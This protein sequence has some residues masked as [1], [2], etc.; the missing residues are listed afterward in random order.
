MK[1]L[2][3]GSDT[4]FAT[5]ILGGK[6]FPTKWT[7]WFYFVGMTVFVKL[8]DLF[9]ECHYVV[10][11]HLID[12]LK[13]LKL[14]KQIKVLVD[15][16]R[17]VKHVERIPHDHI[18]VL[19]YHGVGGNQK[20]KDWVYGYDIFLEL[21]KHFAYNDNIHFIEVTG[22]ANMDF[23]YSITDIYIRPNRSDGNPR[24][25]MECE[26]IGIPYYWSKENPVVS[27]IVDMINVEELKK[28]L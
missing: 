7:K 3:T 4:L 22:G 24:M 12:N 6:K 15:P 11:E 9:V 25:I 5:R 23:L 1:L 8:A 28:N 17:D 20:Y 27:D 13:P 14:K 16:P 26:Q 21:E 10:S 19:Y 18:N 2:F